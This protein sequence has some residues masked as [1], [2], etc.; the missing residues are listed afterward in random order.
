M[1][2]LCDVHISFKL[3]RALESMGHTSTHVNEMP[4]KWHTTDR[5]ISTYAD[6][7][8]YVIITKDADFRDSFF[9]KNSP[10]K[11]IVIKLGNIPNDD[12][13]LLFENNL[14]KIVALQKFASFMLEI[15]KS[16]LRVFTM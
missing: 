16:G 13:I 9:I 12:L 10:K 3:I 1:K 8:D 2:F 7:H 6:T 15:D 4:E 14:Q 11:L 5:E